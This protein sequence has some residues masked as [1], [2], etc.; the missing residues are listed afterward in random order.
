MMTTTRVALVAL[1][2]GLGTLQPVAAQQAP[3]REPTD[4]IND[5]PKTIGRLWA[6][7]QDAFSWTAGIVG[8]ALDYVMPPSPSSLVAAAREDDS[9]DMLKLLGL[10]GYKL[11]EV[12]NEVGLIPGLAFKFAIVRELSEADIDY[13]DEQLDL[14]R[15][16]SP[17]LL[18]Q[19]QRSIVSTVL[20]INSGGG[21][22]VSELKLR[23]L[24]LP[25]AEFS[26][27]PSATLLGEEASALMRAIQ[28]VDRRVRDIAPTSVRTSTD[29]A[30][31]R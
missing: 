7:T 18:G 25:K 19:L 1:L 14:F 4:L 22:Q 8:S 17:G 24:P 2:I 27:T 5:R 20:A 16:R 3:L 12:D 21:M 13:L 15:L 10:A 29:G 28:R 6:A 23:L 11:K 26:V 9:S 30:P 31:R